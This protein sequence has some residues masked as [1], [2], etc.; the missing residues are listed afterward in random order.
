VRSAGKTLYRDQINKTAQAVKELL[1]AMLNPK[2]SDTKKPATHAMDQERP[3]ENSIAVLPFVNMSSDPEQD[4]FSDGITEEILNA[5]AQLRNLKVAGRTSSFQFKG[6]NPDLR[7]VGDKLKVRT[8]LEGS[9]R[10]S[11]NKLRITAQ[12]I[13]V[14][15]GFHIWSE[16]YDRNMDDI[17]AI[18]DEIAGTITEKLKITLLE[19]SRKYRSIRPLSEGQILHG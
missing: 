10:R 15:D 7:K 8:I 1:S 11:G 13:N 6:K 9:V 5:L 19:H 3:V 17:F 14:E 4:Y 12:L 16:K 18:Q 2:K